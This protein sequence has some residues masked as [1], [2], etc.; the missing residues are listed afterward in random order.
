[1]FIYNRDYFQKR[2]DRLKVDRTAVEPIW[3]EI[4]QFVFPLKSGSLTTTTAEKDRTRD[5][6]RHIINDVPLKSVMTLATGMQG[7][8]TSPARKWFKLGPEDSE[9]ED[10]ANIKSYLY[11]VEKLMYSILART[12]FYQTTLDT[13]KHLAAYSLHAFQLMEDSE[14]VVVF[15]PF[16]I[17]EYYLGSDFKGV[18]DTCYREFIMTVS[19]LVEKFGLDKCSAYVQTAYKTGLQDTTVTVVNAVEPNCNY[20]GEEFEKRFINVYYEKDN[21]GSES[22]FLQFNTN[23]SLDDFPLI[24][25]R[26]DT[27]GES[28]YGDNS[29]GF[30]AKGN[31]KML[32][33]QERDIMRATQISIAGPLQTAG[34]IKKVNLSPMGITQ[35]GGVDSTITEIY[36]VNFRIAEAEAKKI[37]T[38]QAIRESFY[39]NLFLL[40]SGENKDMTA[41]ETS[42]RDE[43]KKIMLGN[44]VE[45]VEQ[46]LSLVLTKLYNIMY[47]QDLLPEAPEELQGKQLKIKY[48]SLLSQAQKMGGLN[49]ITNFTSFVSQLA[50]VN[51]EVL[52]KIDLD[53]SIEEYADIIGVPPEM[54]NTEEEVQQIRQARLQQQQQAI[55]SE[56]MMNMVDGAKKLSETKT[57]ESNALTGI[58]E[59]INNG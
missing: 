36:K 35:T 51:P 59:G 20:K 12:N 43:E 34:D 58:M 1:M 9:L 54:M 47:K 50:Q 7:G 26:W 39:N 14:F 52:D 57:G 11:Y 45:R 56:Q 15:K 28:A 4:N 38:E 13:Y 29:P 25:P 40:I 42:I 16:E 21:R 41:Y 23:G 18:V 8:L 24:V 55:Q 33:T 30:M 3:E 49:S 46:M 44:V 6:Y 32:Q 31:C 2:L 37:Q 22:D 19:Q 5:K 10:N 27:I 53:E 17:G 48:I